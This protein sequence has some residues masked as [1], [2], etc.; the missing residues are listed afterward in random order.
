M[1][2]FDIN[3]AVK[4]GNAG[5]QFNQ[6]ENRLDRLEKRAL[7]VR[8]LFRGL[9]AGFSTAIFV[10]E[11]INLS[12]ATIAIENRLKIVSESTEEV[13]RSFDR[14]AEISRRTRSPL[15]ENVA[16]F[17]RAKQA[18]DELGASTQDIFR[19]VEATG[20]A[21]AIQGGAANT[22]R[23]ALI[24]LSQSI[25]ATI[26]R[27]EEFN[28]ILEGALPLAQAAARGIDE[29][30]GSVAKLRQLV[31]SGEISSKEFFEAI[32]S[33]ADN[34]SAIFENT[35]ATISQGFT[36]IRN[37]AIELFRDFN[38]LTGITTLF[39]DTLL[40]LADN[41]DTVARIIGAGIIAAG[42][43]LL[44]NAVIG[45]TSSIVSMTLAIV[46][47][48]LG[49]LATAA[50]ALVSALALATGFIITFSDQIVV[51]IGGTAVP[52][53]DIL[54]EALS[55]LSNLLFGAG[56]NVEGLT[57]QFETLSRSFNVR[58]FIEPLI[59]GFV[60]FQVTASS[61]FD[62]ITEGLRV[63][64]VRFQ[65]IIL[66]IRNFFVRKF[67]EMVNEAIKAFND[68]NNLLPER[69]QFDPIPIQRYGD[70]LVAEI[71]ELEALAEQIISNYNAT[72][73]S[74]MS[75]AT[76]N[77]LASVDNFF[78]RVRQRAAARAE[79]LV[80]SLPVTVAAPDGTTTT[81]GGTTGGTT[82]GSRGG[83][84]GGG[85]SRTSFSDVVAEYEK[86]IVALGRLGQEQRIYNEVLSAADKIGRDLTSTEQDQIAALVEKTEVLQRAS[87]I[88]DQ[89]NGRVEEYAATQAALNQLLESGSINQNEA[90]FALS[91]TQLTQDLAGADQS[92]GGSAA[93][94][95][96]LQQVR[97]YVNE[98]TIIFQQARETDL[99]NEEEYQAR[100][101][102][103]TAS[104]QREVLDLELDRWGLAIS[105]AQSS[106]G[107][108]LGAAEEYAGR[109]SGI[110]K[111]L[112][113]A[114]KAF[115]IAEATVNTFRAVSNALASPFP[116]PIPQT[117]AAAA[118]VAG[119]AQVA[120]IVASTVQGLADGGRV[121]GPG[122]PRD[123]KAGVFALSNGEFVVNAAATAAN[124]PLLEAINRG[125]K[126]GA[127]RDGGIVSMG[128]GLSNAGSNE[129]TAASRSAPVAANVNNDVQVPV[130]VINVSNR[131]EALAAVGGQQGGEVIINQISNNARQIRNVLG[132]EN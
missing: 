122:G 46:T 55:T 47:N 24:Q 61:A 66:E 56:V 96:Q 58:D 125:N 37:S 88:Y 1:P 104:S 98:R 6:L 95:S 118:A 112:F 31:I 32:V 41:L 90:D 9:F 72:F 114:Q 91:Q 65:I 115:A 50:S 59:V 54:L 89:I 83:G 69:L 113:I 43:I 128:T 73:Q 120:A 21:L 78:D 75:E 81:S 5:R 86:G 20:T 11:F 99:I 30:G 93:F 107:V 94:D 63:M 8:G 71:G 40:F 22:A 57:T 116:P 117:L 48:P 53:F 4:D 126:L 124:L 103:L 49:L 106:I 25:G 127:M 131:E 33:E 67:E 129:I 42:I 70:A 28:S 87:D 12:N 45:F 100:L 3:V 123:D 7:S 74:N 2:N 19:F 52:V 15:E 82:G 101:R 111:G 23:G 10:R 17:Q 97:D 14:L 77:A 35:S 132:L 27:A 38:D 18:Q 29:A 16:L 76:E 64:K 79:D 39:A 102:D 85:G 44:T 60:R 34:L 62:R 105:S 121:R 92:I 51:S 84:G 80:F 119:G 26:V 68:F 36:A 13:N 109:Q 110:Y 108:L 130:N